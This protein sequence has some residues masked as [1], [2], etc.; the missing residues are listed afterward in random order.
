MKS[1]AFMG[2][3]NAAIVPLYEGVV[4]FRMADPISVVGVGIPTLDGLIAI[5]RHLSGSR[6]SPAY[7]PLQYKTV[8]W[9]NLREEPILFIKGRPFVLRDLHNPYANVEN[10]GIRAR[11][12]L[13]MEKQLRRDAIVEGLAGNGVLVVHDED[14]DGSLQ[15]ENVFLGAAPEKHENANADAAGVPAKSL[16]ALMGPLIDARSSHQFD[17][18]LAAVP[19]AR[20]APNSIMTTAELFAYATDIVRREQAARGAEPVEVLYA[21]TPVTDEQAPTPLVVDEILRYMDEGAA[22]SAVKDLTVAGGKGGMVV[23]TNCQMGRGRTS[24]AMIIACLWAIGRGF[25]DIPVTELVAVEPPELLE[26]KQMAAA[27]RADEA[28]DG[29]QVDAAA[30]ERREAHAAR[31][32]E[33]WY[34]CVK[35]VV[36]VLPGG[37]E[38]KAHVDRVIDVCGKMQNLRTVIYDTQRLHEGALD[39]KKRHIAEKGRN[40]LV[41]YV[42][43]LCVGS[44]LRNT[45]REGNSTTFSEWLMQRPEIAHA[46]QSAK[47]PEPL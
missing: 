8:V 26:A 14:K 13:A 32:R 46:L 15:Q 5:F 7:Q 44:Y 31:L 34:G 38:D 45:R 40:F 39:S 43:L 18:A 42:M 36:R 4:N 28:A 6:V 17:R 24:T 3:R 22:K 33:G 12:T 35:H 23:V 47:F 21:R 9:L 29:P 27:K 41:R 25:V 19:A 1:D 30:A 10:T 11:R 2:I 16:S 20:Y 37:A